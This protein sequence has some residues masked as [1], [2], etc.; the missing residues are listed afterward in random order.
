MRR[1]D[2][3]GANVFNAPFTQLKGGAGAEHQLHALGVGV[4]AVNGGQSSATAS[5]NYEAGVERGVNRLQAGEA[6]GINAGPV[7]DLRT[8]FNERLLHDADRLDIFPRLL[9]VLV[10]ASDRNVSL[11]GAAE[12]VALDKL[13][14]ELRFCRGRAFVRS[15]E[16]NTGISDARGNLVRGAADGA[17][18]H[19]LNL[20]SVGQRFLNQPDDGVGA[21]ELSNVEKIGLWH[22]LERK[23]L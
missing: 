5:A 1:I 23:L 15:T 9:P 20:G 18:W 6:F 12:D 21:V 3:A 14:L 13:V 11:N 10:S 4:D 8:E 22:G 19:D 17:R 16:S 7:N 2:C